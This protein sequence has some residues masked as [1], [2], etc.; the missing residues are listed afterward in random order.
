M[1][2]SCVVTVIP[3]IGTDDINI[4]IVYDAYRCVD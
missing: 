3:S 4:L 1:D 2:I